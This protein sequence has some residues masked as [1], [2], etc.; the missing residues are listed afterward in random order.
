MR[1]R[2]GTVPSVETRRDVDLGDGKRLVL[3]YSAQTDLLY[4]R[5]L[6][7]LEGRP[8]FLTPPC[9]VTPKKASRFESDARHRHMAK[10]AVLDVPPIRLGVTRGLVVWLSGEEFAGCKEDETMWALRQLLA[11]HG[12]FERRRE[13]ERGPTWERKG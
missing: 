12:S 2:F 11:L 13:L 10:E 6:A 9:E 1:K 7:P 4:I 3:L 8:T 5:L